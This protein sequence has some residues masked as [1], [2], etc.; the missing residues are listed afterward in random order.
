[1]INFFADI[2]TERVHEECDTTQTAPAK[3]T[4]ENHP[5]AYKQMTNCRYCVKSKSLGNFVKMEISALKLDAR[6]N[7]YPSKDYILIENWDGTPISSPVCT[8]IRQ[9][10]IK[11]MA[12]NAIC[13]KFVSNNKVKIL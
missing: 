5:S 3:I 11:A 6:R 1:M 4:S 13:I 10:P 7:C 2:S 9:N 8:I 12:M